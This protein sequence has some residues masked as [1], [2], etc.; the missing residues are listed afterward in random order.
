MTQIA[1]EVMD[2]LGAKPGRRAAEIGCGYGYFTFRL[3]ARVGSEGKVYAVDIK[4]NVVDETRAELVD[5][6]TRYALTF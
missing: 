5:N 6:L 1:G 2:A 4:D 3:A